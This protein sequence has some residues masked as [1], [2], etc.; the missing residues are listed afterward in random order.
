MRRIT[1]P[2][3]NS[4]GVPDHLARTATCTFLGW[5]FSAATEPF[6]QRLTQARTTRTQNPD[7]QR[8]PIGD[9]KWV[10]IYPI[11]RS[12]GDHYQKTQRRGSLLGIQR[13]FCI[14]HRV[15]LGLS[16]PYG[17]HVFN[18]GMPRHIPWVFGLSRWV[19]K[20]SSGSQGFWVLEHV[21]FSRW[22]PLVGCLESGQGQWRVG[23][24][25]VK[26]TVKLKVKESD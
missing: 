22:Q 14:L 2:A 7:R 6:K 19:F 21:L 10:R 17:L 1:Y 5:R 12:T 4:T 16:F 24:G 8:V 23:S 25:R 9:W 18:G 11:S 15:L 13:I 20:G 3:S 26:S